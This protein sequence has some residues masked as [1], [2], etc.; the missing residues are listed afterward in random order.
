MLKHT[1]TGTLNGIINC[2]S[3]PTTL[4]CYLDL[5]CPLPHIFRIIGRQIAPVGADV[6]KALP[7]EKKACVPVYV[8]VCVFVC[9]CICGCMCACMCAYL[10]NSVPFDHSKCLECWQTFGRHCVV[11][12]LYIYISLLAVHTNQKRFQCERPR[13]KRDMDPVPEVNMLYP[14]LAEVKKYKKLLVNDGDVMKKFKLH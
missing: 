14:A 6:A 13:E 8:C 9:V 4:Q 11:L 5:G 3:E 7:E 1:H 2:L 12:Y 10:L